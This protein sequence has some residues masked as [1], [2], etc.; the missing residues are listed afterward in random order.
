MGPGKSQEH[1]WTGAARIVDGRL[2]AAVFGDL[3]S[4][5]EDV[6]GDAGI[7]HLDRRFGG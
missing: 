7:E 4:L 1:P 5:D 2:S 3:T 6:L